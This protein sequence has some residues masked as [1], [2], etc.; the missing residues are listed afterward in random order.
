MSEMTKDI[1]QYLQTKFGNSIEESNER[2]LYQALMAETRNRLLKKR[3]DYNKKLKESGQKQAYYMSKFFSARKDLISS[4][5][6]RLNRLF[7]S[8][9]PTKNSIDI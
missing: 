7:L 2:Q 6:P 8:V 1:E 3:Y 9:L 4:S 5:K